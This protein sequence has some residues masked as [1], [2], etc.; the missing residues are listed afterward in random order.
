MH[1]GLLHVVGTNLWHIPIHGTDPQ[2]FGVCAAE[3]AMCTACGLQLWLPSYGQEP[4]AVQGQ[5]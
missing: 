4:A 1:K 5:C 2:G 3:G